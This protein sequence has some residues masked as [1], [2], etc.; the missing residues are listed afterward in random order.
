M[1]ESLNWL[2][3]LHIME[4]TADRI[5]NGKNILPSL[6]KIFSMS[7]IKCWWNPREDEIKHTE[8]KVDIR[9]SNCGKETI[10]YVHILDTT[11]QEI[12]TTFVLNTILQHVSILWIIENYE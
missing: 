8:V 12:I 11:Y 4:F 3:F 10:I 9:C 7:K 5:E 1:K 2:P 6:L